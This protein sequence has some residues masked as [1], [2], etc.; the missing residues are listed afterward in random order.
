MG[1]VGGDVDGERQ[2]VIVDKSRNFAI[3]IIRLYQHLQ[4]SH[5]PFV[6]NT[7]LLKCGTSIGANIREGEMG[8]S[9]ADFYAKLSIAQKE[10]NETDFWL[11]ILHETGYLSDTEYNSIVADCKEII[12]ILTA[13]LKTLKTN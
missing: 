10:A 13:I 9:S 12:Y 3:R 6:M 7:Q 5:C 8:Q 2:N 4:K 1:M 11:D